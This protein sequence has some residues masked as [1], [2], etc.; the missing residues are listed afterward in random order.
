MYPLTGN[1]TYYILV[2][3]GYNS[4]DSNSN[5]LGHRDL[6][7]VT[8]EFCLDLNHDGFCDAD[9]TRIGDS[10]IPGEHVETQMGGCPTTAYAVITPE[11]D[12]FYRLATS[13][14]NLGNDPIDDVDFS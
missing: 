5:D 13:R 11:E 9:Q 6:R 8:H 3:L 12:G 7:V 10:I 1:T 4:T 14:I 2:N